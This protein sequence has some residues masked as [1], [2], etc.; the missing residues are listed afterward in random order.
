MSLDLANVGGREFSHGFRG[1]DTHEV[2]AYLTALGAEID[3]LVVAKREAEAAAARGSEQAGEQVPLTTAVGEQAARVLQ[4]AED[5]AG[6]IRAR[7]EEAVAKMLRDAQDEVTAERARSQQERADAASAAEQAAQGIRE[8]AEV[9]LDEAREEGRAMVE[10]ARAI[11][12]RVLANLAEKRH[13]ARRELG[14]LR[15]G[16]DELRHAYTSL[17]EL[18]DASIDQLERAVPDARTAAMRAGETMGDDPEPFGEDQ[19]SAEIERGGPVVLGELDSPAFDDLPVDERAAAESTESD[20]NEAEADDAP[21]DLEEGV[22]A[23]EASGDQV[24]PV[25]TAGDEADIEPEL[26]SEDAATDADDV[27]AGDAGDDAEV[28]EWVAA[29]DDG[30]GD[31]EL[32]DAPDAAVIDLQAHRNGVHAGP[33][34]PEVEDGDLEATEP[35]AEDDPELPEGDA[36]DER[37]QAE[38]RQLFEDG[39]Q[40][41]RERGDIDELFARIRESRADAVA[42]AREVMDRTSDL[43]IIT[44][45]EVSPTVE[46]GDFLQERDE[47]LEEFGPEAAL[48]LKRALADHLNEV[49]DELRRS[50]DGLVGPDVLISEAAERQLA[51]AVRDHLVA[52]SVRGSGGES[53]DVGPVVRA[54]GA[55]LGSS[56]RARLEGHGD[57]AAQLEG[58][59]R[60]VYREW[61]RDRVDAAASDALAAA[62]GLGLLSSVPDGTPVRWLAPENACQG[63]DCEENTLASDVLAGQPFPSGHVMAPRGP[64]CR[65]LVVPADQ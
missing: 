21:T 28:P 23:E 32:H 52:A 4:A 12:A 13:S 44:V 51:E 29:G 65:G 27:D 59:V 14:Q 62:F 55:D 17:G 20:A 1:Y 7:A 56:M 9:E 35:L 46:R 40:P 33:K 63:A 45:D 11:R 36:I 54:L 38:R 16:I 53:V 48:A 37:R 5:A 25:D 39:A 19:V 41:H 6:D 50:P 64:G 3:L 2:R 34:S 22:G 31:D 60:S 24:A 18:L 10:E 49:L 61:R 15:A 8:R 43:P 57:D 47:T 26:A 58:R 30:A 42:Q